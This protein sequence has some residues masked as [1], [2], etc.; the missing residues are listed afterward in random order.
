MLD[1]SA[2]YLPRG[3][4]PSD[5]DW[6]I[7]NTGEILVGEFSSSC[8]LWE[9][10]SSG[11]RKLYRAMVINGAVAALCRH[12]VPT[13]RQINTRDDVKSFQVMFGRDG[14]VGCSILYD[15]RRWV[16]FVE[17]WF[18][19]P[20]YLKRVLWKSYWNRKAVRS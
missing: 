3:I 5:I 20:G 16:R 12:E 11:Q 10:V 13:D 9:Q 14:T 1:N 7:D 18:R 4:T 19:D 8:E 17:E 15:G 2:W 6:C